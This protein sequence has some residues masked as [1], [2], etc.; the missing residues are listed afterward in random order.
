MTTWRKT[1]RDPRIWENGD[2]YRVGCFKFD[3]K[4]QALDYCGLRT[5]QEIE[6]A[7]PFLVDED[8]LCVHDGNDLFTYKGQGFYVLTGPGAVERYWY[9]GDVFE[10]LEELLEAIE[11]SLPPVAYIK[12]IVKPRSA[13]SFL[14]YQTVHGFVYGNCTYKSL[15]DATRHIENEQEHSGT[16]EYPEWAPDWYENRTHRVPIF[17]ARM[18]NMGLVYRH[19]DQPRDSWWLSVEDALEGKSGYTEYN[20]ATYKWLYEHGEVEFFFEDQ[21]WNNE[22]RLKAFIDGRMA[23]QLQTY[24]HSHEG[25]KYVKVCDSMF[26]VLYFEFKGTRYTTHVEV[27]KAIEAAIEAD[28]QKEINTRLN[29]VEKSYKGCTYVEVSDSMLNVLYYE[30]E[31][32]RYTTHVGLACAIDDIFNKGQRVRCVEAGYPPYYAVTQRDTGHFLGYEFEGNYFGS[33]EALKKRASWLKEATALAASLNQNNQV[34]VH[35]NPAFSA[36]PQEKSMK[37][38]QIEI[39][40]ANLNAVRTNVGDGIK[41][42]LAAATLDQATEIFTRRAISMGAP[43]DFVRSEFFRTTM[44]AVGTPFLLREIASNVGGNA[45]DKMHR[46]AAHGSRGASANASAKL[47]GPLLAELTGLVNNA[48]ELTDSA[49]E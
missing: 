17:E 21:F 22:E 47:F 34:P 32:T 29:R 27:V 37:Q 6:Q 18:G 35:N 16:D 2:Y 3:Y 33:L 43:E 24:H 1:H 4:T 42:G 13:C 26:N 46:L 23:K 11:L 5:E 36:K 45:G 48:A 19:P 9:A 30:F 31:G 41:D 39:A 25:C 44:N 15:D 20:G 10:E 14:V 7:N 49:G 28:Q 12:N 40:S 8:V 38:N